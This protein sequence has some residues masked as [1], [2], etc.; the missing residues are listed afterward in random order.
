MEFKHTQ[1]NGSNYTDADI[2]RLIAEYNVQFIKLQF[3]DINGQIK[4]LAIPAEHIDRILNNIALPHLYLQEFYNN[5]IPN[6]HPPTLNS[7]EHLLSNLLSP[8]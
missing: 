4:N 3:V 7:L 6:K 5:L 2:K 8:V 1:L